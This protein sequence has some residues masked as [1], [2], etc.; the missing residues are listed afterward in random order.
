[1]KI[2]VLFILSGYFKSALVIFKKLLELN[3]Q[4]TEILKLNYSR[5]NET[6]NHL[7]E[8]KIKRQIKMHLT[9]GY[10]NEF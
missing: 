2:Q 9:H 7:N 3:F 6:M 10:K 1:M 8:I 4:E 5:C